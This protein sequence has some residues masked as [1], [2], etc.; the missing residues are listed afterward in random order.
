MNQRCRSCV[1]ESFDQDISA[2]VR[3]H[4]KPLQGRIPVILGQIDNCALTFMLLSIS[5]ELHA[6][7]KAGVFRHDLAAGLADYP[8]SNARSLN[9]VL[10]VQLTRW[11]WLRSSPCP[12]LN[13]RNV[14][15]A[16]PIALL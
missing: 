7:Q 10:A 6:D 13:G 5:K 11:S 16:L 4:S 15:M 3:G 8:S 14:L 12:L 2:E 1:P 9:N